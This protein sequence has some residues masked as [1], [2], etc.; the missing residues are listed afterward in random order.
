MKSEII[1]FSI[2][3]ALIISSI[4]FQNVFAEEYY[5]YVDKLP[6]WANY[7][8]NVMYESTK[9][10]ED[11]N[12][13]LK[14]YQAS[15][16]T[17]ADFIVKWTRDFGQEHVGYAYGTQ[18]I[19][20]G[21][22]DSGCGGKWEP[23]SSSHVA[24]IMKHEIGHILGLGHSDDPNDIMYPIALNLEYGLV[25]EQF[26][27]TGGYAQFV[28]LCTIKDVTSY[29]YNVK[30]S[31]PNVGFDVYFVPSVDEFY[32]W[33][34]GKEFQ[35]YSDKKCFG[36]GYISYGGTCTGVSGKGGLLIILDN[37]YSGTLTTITV[38]QEEHS[39]S[40]GSSNIAVSTIPERDSDYDG[41]NDNY[42]SC[43]Y[44]AENFNGYQDLDGCPDTKP[45]V[46][47]DGDG[48]FD[49]KDKCVL[50]AETFNGYQDSDGCPDTKPIDYKKEV[51]KI[52]KNTDQK[53]NSLKSG[54]SSAE[55][56]IKSTNHKNVQAKEEVKKA[57]TALWWAKKYFGDAELTQKQGMSFI[58]K[59]DFKSAYYKYKYS[60]ESAKKIEPY[61][62]D[63]TKYLAN[64]QK[65]AS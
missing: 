60:F 62:F 64:A 55:K 41:I 31:D 24:E 5:V 40:S 33:S 39:T 44:S 21:L 61:L 9:A 3:G 29:D 30:S 49:N 10:W 1:T 38:Q 2:L 59:S 54:I 53:I 18:F 20:V 42:D 36:E 47:S 6:S 65:L 35:Y 51:L 17:S 34:D 12:P 63:I 13:G 26:T 48:I 15:S 58:S 37:N 19:E 45:I 56:S 28:S 57:W 8:G 32:K 7:A 4:S 11:A 23:Y 14:F 25:E 22:G 50:K 27:L 16:Q 43:V 46:D 52:Q